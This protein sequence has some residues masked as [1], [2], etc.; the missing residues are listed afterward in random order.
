MSYVF[1]QI[2]S[3]IRTCLFTGSTYVVV[4]IGLAKFKQFLCHTVIDCIASWC[5]NATFREVLSTDAL[6][7]L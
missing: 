2:M 4:C 1:V 6:K 7:V 3:V 5:A